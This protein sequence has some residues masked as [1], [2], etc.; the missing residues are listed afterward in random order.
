MSEWIERKYE[1][2][3]LKWGRMWGTENH[4]VRRKPWVYF[5]LSALRKDP[6]YAG[7]SIGGHTVEEWFGLLGDF[8]KQYVEDRVL[9]GMWIEPGG[10]YAHITFDNMIDLYEAAPDPMVRQHAKMFLDLALIEDEQ[11]SVNGYRAGARSRTPAMGDTT[12]KFKNTVFGDKPGL[13]MS[14]YQAPPIAIVLRNANGAVEPYHISNRVPGENAPVKPEFARNS[15][16]VSYAYRTPGYLLGSV[17]QDPNRNYNPTSDQRRWSGLIF[18]SDEA[19]YPWP[20]EIFKTKD[21]GRSSKAFWG[22]QHDGTMVVQ[23]LLKS[24][25]WSS[26]DLTFVDGVITLKHLAGSSTPRTVLVARDSEPLTHGAIIMATVQMEKGKS[27]EVGDI[28]I[29]SLPG[30]GFQPSVADPQ[31]IRDATLTTMERMNRDFINQR[32]ARIKAMEYLGGL[33]GKPSKDVVSALA[34]AACDPDLEVRLAAIGTM[35]RLNVKPDIRASLL[36]SLGRTDHTIRARAMAMLAHLKVTPEKVVTRVV[37]GLMSDQRS[38][39]QDFKMFIQAAGGSGDKKSGKALRKEMEKAVAEGKGAEQKQKMIADKLKAAANPLADSVFDE[40]K[41][42][43]ASEQ[44]EKKLAALVR[45]VGRDSVEEQVDSDSLPFLCQ[46]LKH[47]SPAVRLA[48]AKAVRWIETPLAWP[49]VNKQVKNIFKDNPEA[50]K[51]ITEALASMAA[52]EVPA[53]RAQAV[54]ALIEMRAMPELVAAMLGD[55]DAGVRLAAAEGLCTYKRADIQNAVPALKALASDERCQV[56]AA[57]ALKYIEDNTIVDHLEK[58]LPRDVVLNKGEPVTPEKMAKLQ[59]LVVEAKRIG[60]AVQ[61]ERVPFPDD[62]I[63][64]ASAQLC[65]GRNREAANERLQEHLRVFHYD[66]K[67]A[68]DA[69]VIALAYALH[70][71]KSRY[72]PGG[73]TPETEA[74]YKAMMFS[75]VDWNSHM[76]FDKVIDNVMRLPGTENQSLTYRFG[77]WFLFLDLLKDDPDFVTFQIVASDPETR[78]LAQMF[79]DVHFVDEAQW[80]FEYVRGGGKSRV[81]DQKP[82]GFG[83][84]GDAEKLYYLAIPYESK[85][86]HSISVSSYSAPAV[87]V[88]MWNECQYPA[89][90]IELNN[91]RLGELRGNDKDPNAE[92]EGADGNGKDASV[93][94]DD[95]G[96][97]DTGPVFAADSKLRNYGWKTRNYL[98]G[99]ILRDPNAKMEPICEQRQW[100]G[101]TFADGSTIAPF[102]VAGYGFQHRNV[103]LFQQSNTSREIGKMSVLI[104][105][106]LEKIE[107]GG[108]V[109]YKSGKGYAAIKPLKGAYRWDGTNLFPEDQLSPLVIQGGDEDEYGSYEKFV[110]SVL[111]NQI[112]VADDK[113]EFQSPGQPKIEFFY[114]STGKLSRVDGKEVDLRPGLVYSSPNLTRKEGSPLVEA[115]A[116]MYS[117]TYNLDDLTVTEEVKK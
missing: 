99:S 62:M 1:I 59:P 27:V 46:A 81:K 94:G 13:L 55:K 112:L 9:T 103:Y 34:I 79:L 92:N 52:Q 104:S 4:D 105:P 63:S 116:G 65:L 67:S 97:S 8:M 17:L 95:S 54:G 111:K 14:D 64:H 69:P 26:F 108:W 91:R 50:A 11:I 110:D 39:R 88:A 70:N 56:A 75:V 29:T 68:L 20:K 84:F 87:A 47:P 25:G 114:E 44:E 101:I 35:R 31:K 51:E 23:K 83:V 90:P 72:F 58:K 115:Q 22:I 89:K 113:V 33:P 100:N 93:G 38:A 74:L 2:L 80:G 21:S 40:I 10:H 71:S 32:S 60:I 107:R 12:G 15:H 85:G 96:E 37:D 43:F 3:P 24:D 61:A 86:A 16:L 117:A 42:R 36:E 98:L 66:D 41:R 6:A 49:S 45:A 82:S 57:A 102:S 73:L 18:Q 30:S 48:A 7:K 28:T 19:V 106:S 78:K 77:Q 5:A 53:V 76:L 109:F